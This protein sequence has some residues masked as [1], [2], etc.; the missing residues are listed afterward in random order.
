[1]GNGLVLGFNM[2]SPVWLIGCR[3]GSPHSLLNS[4]TLK[5]CLITQALI[6]VCICHFEI[7]VLC[8]QLLIL[9]SRTT[10]ILGIDTTGRG[11]VC[12]NLLFDF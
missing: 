9:L 7:C 11:V 3:I 5:V 1:M 8:V 12:N 6:Y 2:P 4:H 10:D